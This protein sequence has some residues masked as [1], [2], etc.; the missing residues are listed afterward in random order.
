[1]HLI[2]KL[3]NIEWCLR[4]NLPPGL[5]ALALASNIAAILPLPPIEVPIGNEAEDMAY[6]V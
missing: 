3:K 4:S 1:M 6:K 5:F 2:L